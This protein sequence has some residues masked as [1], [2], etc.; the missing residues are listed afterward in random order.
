MA[1]NKSDS[2]KDKTM[3][4]SKPG[5]RQ[6]STTSRPIIVTNRSVIKDPMVNAKASSAQLPKEEVESDTK[7]KRELNIKPPTNMDNAEEKNDEKTAV[8]PADDNK[9]VTDGK[10]EAPAA[11]TP[12]EKPSLVAAVGATEAPAP[13]EPVEPEA[14][15]VEEPVKD[16]DKQQNIEEQKA[17]EEQE[18]V[19][20]ENERT[21]KLVEQKTYFLPIG[22]VTR[23]LHNRNAFIALGVILLF[24]AAFLLVDGKIINLGFDLPVHLLPQ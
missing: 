6:S 21:R 7:V 16:D 18:R 8:E 12:K 17:R 1:T 15:P 9:S 20:H 23:R 22:E 4:V 11:E 10:T 2:A 19:E 24:V 13:E 5:E 14:A 3:D